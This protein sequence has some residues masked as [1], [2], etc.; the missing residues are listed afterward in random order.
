MTPPGSCPFPSSLDTNM[1]CVFP[2]AEA[3]NI[4]RRSED[5]KRSSRIELAPS[6]VVRL[7]ARA[8]AHPAR[9]QLRNQ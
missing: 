3:E 6:R 7:E 1:G 4:K 5:K 9:A 2:C 8:G